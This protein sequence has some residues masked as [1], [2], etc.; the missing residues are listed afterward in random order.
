MFL[1]AIILVIFTYFF[2][3]N[4]LLNFIF[5]ENN[6]KNIFLINFFGLIIYGLIL[7][8]PLFSGAV[9][10]FSGKPTD[11]IISTLGNSPAFIKLTVALFFAYTP[12]LTA[13]LA[14]VFFILF[15]LKKYHKK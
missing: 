10:F 4:L 5:K 9:A 11:Y 6:Y 14:L 7:Y 8:T 1:A 12:I 3:F 2:I 15:Y 13:T